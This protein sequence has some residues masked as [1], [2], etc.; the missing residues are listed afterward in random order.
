M[1]RVVDA[2]QGGDY[3]DLGAEMVASHASQRDDY[4]VSVPEIDTLVETALKHGALGARLTGGGFGGCI[5]ALVPD[6]R[7]QAWRHAVLGDCP[8]AWQVS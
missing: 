6:R 2:M 1:L 8:T 5:V 7:Y 3:A 4:E